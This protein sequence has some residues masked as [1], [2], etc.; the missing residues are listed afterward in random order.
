MAKPPLSMKPTG[1][2]QIAWS[3]EIAA[4]DVHTMKYFDQEMVAWRA[5]SGQLTVMNAYCEH[6][7]AHLGFGGTVLGEV[8]QCPFHGWQWNQQGRNVCIPYEDRPNR[9]RRIRTYPVVERNESVYIWH[10]VENR[11][12]FFDAPDVFASFAD[13]TTATDYH[14]QQRLFEQGLE[15]HPQYVLENGVDVAHFKYVH[16][17]PINPIFTRHDFDEPVSYV[18]FTITF[19]GD[20]GQRIE[21]VNSGVEAINGGL[22]IAVTKSWGMIDNRTIS[23]I[24]PVDESTSDVRFMVYIGR[25]KSEA[26]TRNPDRARIKAEEFGLEVIRQFRQDIHIWAHQRYSDPPALAGSEMAGFTAI[27]TWAKRF[28]PAQ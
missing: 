13:G 23:C 3:D 18:D 10:D 14:Q 19:E 5:E 22:G 8:L 20:D 16:G 24:T 28:Y 11:E 7:G 21:D 4:G 6:L 9:G 17:T 2:F 25:P 1:W 27:R 12:P 26:A 15:M